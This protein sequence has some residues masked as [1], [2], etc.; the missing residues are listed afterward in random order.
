[1]A[2]VRLDG[3]SEFR[4][5]GGEGIWMPM[6]VGDRWMIDTE[7]GTVAIPLLTDPDVA[8]ERLSEPRRFVVPE[9]WQDWL[10]QSFNLRVTPLASQGYSQE[11]LADLLR[12]PGARD[13]DTAGAQTPAFGPTSIPKAG[14]A[15]VVA[16]ELLRNPALDLTIT[17]WSAR[18]LSSPRTL[19]R[20]FRSGTGLTFAQWR[21]RCRLDAA[22]E[23]IAAGYDVGHV[24]PRVGFATVNGFARAFKQRFSVTP[25]MFGLTSS[26][27]PPSRRRTQRVLADR[28]TGDLMR[29]MRA[30]DA[31][32]APDTLPAARTASHTNSVHVLIWTY[33]GRGYVDIGDRRFEQGR[34][35]ATWIPA[36]TEHTTGVYEDSVSLPLGNADAADLQLEKPLQV[37]FTSDWDDYLLFCSIS[38]RTPLRPTDYNPG[39]VLDLFAD[40]VAAQ[41]ALSVPMPVDPRARAAAMDCLRTIAT[42]GRSRFDVSAD[43]HRAF[44]EQTG[45][46]F[47]RWRYAARMRI[48]RD[49]L[50]GGAKTSAVARRVGY[51]H[52][53]TF[54][55]AFTRFHG[56]SPSAFQGRE[57]TPL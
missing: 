54:S 50:A 8:A 57:A 39:D 16:E 47:A 37:R 33:R 15:R 20:D 34:G 22:V 30:A 11:A 38:A 46:T 53:S 31:P 6:T 4:V 36:G 18:V 7:P 28:Q 43:T 13:G 24:A 19:L 3:G 56:L 35:V 32:S 5:M 48:A 29:M 42:P 41:R 17:E 25:T 51:A 9:A 26:A 23:F 55:A 12:R 10:I 45:M 14:G 2:R 27:L 1:M 21:M 49:L 40:Q 52:L 44:R